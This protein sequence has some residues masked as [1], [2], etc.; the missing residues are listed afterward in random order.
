LKEDNILLDDMKVKD[1]MTVSLSSIVNDTKSVVIP[2]IDSMEYD[3]NHLLS[4][5]NSSMN[6][7]K[8]ESQGNHNAVPNGLNYSN[9]Y[10]NSRY[11]LDPYQM[12]TLWQSNY[13][14]LCW[15]CAPSFTSPVMSSQVFIN[16][17]IPTALAKHV[18]NNNVVSVQ[19][20][21]SH[22]I[23]QNTLTS[24]VMNDSTTSNYAQQQSNDT[25]QPR[26]NGPSALKRKLESTNGG[27]E[28]QSSSSNG[29]TDL[30]LS[31]LL[32][33]KGRSSAGGDDN[34]RKGR[35]KTD[36]NG[37]TFLIRTDSQISV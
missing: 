21:H 7:N 9:E 18:P 14:N 3:S 11:I 4:L 17:F 15:P 5:K 23:T 31:L 36:E 35:P 10:Q 28:T 29:V 34:G 12:C 33:K 19:P 20:S 8:N 22:P 25:A 1:E 16:P 26:A 6:N 37:H 32:L 27:N 24:R 13:M 30:V 2:S